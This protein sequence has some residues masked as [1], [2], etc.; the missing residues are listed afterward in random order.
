MRRLPSRRKRRCCGARGRI[1]SRARPPLAPACGQH[2]STW[3]H[4]GG[5][6]DVLCALAGVQLQGEGKTCPLLPSEAV[7]QRLAVVFGYTTLL[8]VVF[9]TLALLAELRGFGLSQENAHSF[10]LMVLDAIPRTATMEGK[11]DMETALVSFFE[12]NMTPQKFEPP[13]ALPCFANG[14]QVL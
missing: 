9:T 7:L 13:S 1:S 3:H 2:A 4:Q 5:G 12:T 8:K 6:G 14:A 11:H 10:V